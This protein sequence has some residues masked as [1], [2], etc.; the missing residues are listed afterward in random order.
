[1]LKL[2]KEEKEVINQLHSMTSV[3]KSDI[4]DFFEMLVALIVVLWERG[5]GVQVPLF[6]EFR[7][8]TDSGD[9]KTIH[10]TPSP[11]MDTV[12]EQLSLGQK[13]DIENIIEEKILV[14][15]AKDIN[16]EKEEDEI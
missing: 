14:R 11:F 4:L 16:P 8:L 7:V 1:M 15:L 13:T 2:S 10:F 9:K 3:G 6:G 5:E 12:M